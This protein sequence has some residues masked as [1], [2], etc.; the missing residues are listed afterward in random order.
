MKETERVMGSMLL[1]LLRYMVNACWL[2]ATFKRASYHTHVR[3]PSRKGTL[4]MIH[5][6][7]H[8]SD[9]DS[10]ASGVHQDARTEVIRDTY[11]RTCSILSLTQYAHQGARGG[12]STHEFIRMRNALR[13][14]Y[15]IFAP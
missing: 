1:T 7:T 15:M 8:A 10:H 14:Y 11:M 9:L 3:V 5:D 12:K 4:L 6:I 13:I 2:R